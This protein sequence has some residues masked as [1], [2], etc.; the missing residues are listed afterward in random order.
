MWFVLIRTLELNLPLKQN[1]IYKCKGQYFYPHK[2]H[3]YYYFKVS[4]TCNTSTDLMMF[5]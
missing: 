5:S 2:G 1:L 3:S 4:K